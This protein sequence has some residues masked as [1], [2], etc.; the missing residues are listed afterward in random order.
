MS[1]KVLPMKDPHESLKIPK[2]HYLFNLPMRLI[3]CGAS[4][5][6]G[7]TNLIGN[8]LIRWYKDDFKPEDTYI[9]Q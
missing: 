8:M 2:G 5:R 7:K 6:S 3:I 4:E 1:L 9:F